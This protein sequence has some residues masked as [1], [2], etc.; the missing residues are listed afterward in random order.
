MTQSNQRILCGTCRSDLTGP[1]EH[2]DDSIFKCLVCGQEEELG[3]IRPRAQ[4]ISLRL[5]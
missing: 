3:E 5:G 1:E 2:N 4:E